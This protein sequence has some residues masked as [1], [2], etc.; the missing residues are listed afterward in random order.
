MMSEI[1]LLPFLVLIQ[2]FFS[3]IETGFVSLMHSKIFYRSATGNRRA[4][5]LLFFREHPNQFFSTVLVGIN[6][7][8][9]LTATLAADILA[10]RHVPDYEFL[11]PLILAPVLI[12]FGESLP[13]LFFRKHS[14]TMTMGTEPLLE[15]F[16]IILFPAVKLFGAAIHILKKTLRLGRAGELDFREEEVRAAVHDIIRMKKSSGFLRMNKEILE[17]M[18]APLSSL[19]LNEPGNIPMKPDRGEM[20]RAMTNIGKRT[21][22]VVKNEGIKALSLESLISGISDPFEDASSFYEETPLGFV[23]LDLFQKKVRIAV[24]LDGDGRP[25][26]SMHRDEII[27]RLF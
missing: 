5:R 20:V 19:S 6:I 15:F 3:G 23:L 7:V 18:H 1:I 11:A 16:Y 26:N 9:V 2:A 13:K 10:Q 25:Y 27:A 21:V 4:K 22:F 14:H 24:I 17:K 8:S 12:I